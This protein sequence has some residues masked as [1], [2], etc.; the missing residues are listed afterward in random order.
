MRCWRT[1][2]RF[3][4]ANLK[5]KSCVHLDLGW[6]GGFMRREGSCVNS[7]DLRNFLSGSTG[8]RVG[9]LLCCVCLSSH[10]DFLFFAQAQ[11]FSLFHQFSGPPALR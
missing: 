9:L 4:P 3:I 11:E 1:D 10:T 8:G 5:R 2:R 6:A 7:Q